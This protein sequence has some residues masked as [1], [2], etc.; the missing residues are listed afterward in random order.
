MAHRYLC[1]G[2]ADGRL[3]FEGAEAAHLARVLR[4]QPGAQL[5]AF[6]GLGHD[7]IC[8]V[9][10]VSPQR[11]ECE[12]LSSSPSASEPSVAV[13]LYVGFPKGDKL[14]LIIQKAV[15]LGAVRIV[16]FFCRC[17]VVT[18]KNEAAKNQR[19][20]R[21]ALEAAKQSGRGIVPEVALPLTFAQVLGELPAFDAALFCWEAQPGGVPLRERLAGAHS[22]A[23]VTG[24][25]GG[26]APEEVTAAAALAA[27]VS[28][29][30]RILRC[31]TAPI[32]ALSAV[33]AFTGNLE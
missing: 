33:M 15:E 19:Y 28:L 17:C 10:A 16:P 1:T 20:R 24:P 5:T 31:E 26:F 11:V 9:S 4:V 25:E 27:P 13:T 12:I 8:R 22:V 7:Y 18:P 29:G 3:A 23:V 32:A 2:A 30:P 14:E 21:I 6:D